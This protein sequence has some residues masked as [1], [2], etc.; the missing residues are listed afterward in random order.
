MPRKPMVVCCKNC[1]NWC[2]DECPYLMRGM[3]SDEKC[4]FYKEVVERKKK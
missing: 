1:K 4:Q 3:Y 2:K